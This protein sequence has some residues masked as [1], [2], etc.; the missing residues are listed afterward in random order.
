MSKAP[1]EIVD[2]IDHRN[3][4]STQRMLVVDRMP[5]IVYE[6]K[7]HGQWLYGHDS[8][9]FGFYAYE[10]PGPNWKA[11]AGRKFGIPLTDGTV[12]EASGQWWDPGLPA[13]F[14]GLVY[15]C[16]MNTI[17]ALSQ[18]YVFNGGIYTDCEIVDA[19]LEANE[20]SNNYN[21]YDARH[22]D[23]SKHT[24][25]SRWAGEALK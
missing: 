23:Y 14:R 3:K 12:I 10:T 24:I 1:I 15:S 6:R 20:P 19:W 5:D 4:Y 16:A 25:T 22:D 17:D 7:R 11:F 21:K 8:G 9:C 18:C 13:E 2:I